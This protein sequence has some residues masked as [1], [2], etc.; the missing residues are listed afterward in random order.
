[1]LFQI[2][3]FSDLYSHDLLTA[4]VAQCFMDLNVSHQVARSILE[5]L[6]ICIIA[7]LIAIPRLDISYHVMLIEI[8]KLTNH[9]IL[10]T[11]L[12]FAPLAWP[13]ISIWFAW[14]RQ[15]FFLGPRLHKTVFKLLEHY[16]I[17]MW[18]IVRR[19]QVRIAVWWDGSSSILS[20]L[21]A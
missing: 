17:M 5:L 12:L 18:T 16:L 9:R 15:V 19:W 2:T 11:V 21:T 20:I 14:S 3:Y 13:N 8:D 4:S 6:K 7:I 10:Y 1:M